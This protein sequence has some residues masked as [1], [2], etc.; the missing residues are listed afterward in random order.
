MKNIIIASA[1]FAISPNAGANNLTQF[2]F[3]PAQPGKG[4]LIQTT[5]DIQIP[6][7]AIPNKQVLPVDPNLFQTPKFKAIPLSLESQIIIDSLKVLLGP[8]I[9]IRGIDVIDM[10]ASTQVY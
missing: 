9:E 1:M 3:I 5:A 4:L 10:H 6:I 2:A 7:N 8:S